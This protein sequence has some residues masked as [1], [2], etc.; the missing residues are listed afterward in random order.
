MKPGYS[1]T[2]ARPFDLPFLA[3]IELAT[4]RL[5]VGHAPESVLNTATDPAALWIRM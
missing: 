2:K 4:A 5:L 3:A 1:I